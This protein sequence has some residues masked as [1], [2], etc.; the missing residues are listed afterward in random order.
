MECER[1]LEAHAFLF[2][3]IDVAGWYGR[4]ERRCVD[5]ALCLRIMEQARGG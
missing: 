3:V 1:H 2:V 5:L 4:H